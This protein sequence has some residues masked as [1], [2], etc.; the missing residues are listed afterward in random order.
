MLRRAVVALAAGLLA[1]PGAVRAQ[2][3]SCELVESQYAER[4]I[5][6]GFQVIHVVGPLRVVCAG[7]AEIRA[8]EGTLYE[9]TREIYLVGNVSYSDPERRLTSNNATYGSVNGR[10]HATGNVVF[11]DLT[12]GMTL[13]G[14]ELEYF[15]AMVGRPQAQAIATG[16]PH[17]VLQPRARAGEAARPADAQPV[18]VDADRMTM[19]GDDRLS[20]VGRVEIRRSDFTAFSTEAQ[21]D[22]ANDR[23]QLRGAARVH[24]EDFDLTG[25]VVEVFLPGE[26][27]ERVLAQQDA[28]LVGD[29]LRI[30]APEM[31]LFFADDVLQRLVAR[32]RVGGEASAIRRPV[33]SARAFRLEADSLDALLPGQQLERVVAIGDARGEAIDTAGVPPGRRTAPAPAGDLAAGDRDWITGDTVT[34]FFAPADTAAVAADAGEAERERPAEVQLER[35]LARGSARSLYRA[36]NESDPAQPPGLNYLVGETI[37]LSFRNGELEVAD[38]RGLQYGLYLDPAEPGQPVESLPPDERT[39]ARTGINRQR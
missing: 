34:G 2:A 7:G 17:L 31:H 21:L 37:E 10:L 26:S 32:N 16:R 28:V 35:L 29:D 24:A 36:Q 33:A 19:I 20:A 11:T 9:T 1:L 13:T 15:R 18:E 4:R 8:N 22:R 30:D 39:G 27:L 23:M 25:E 12:E 3:G 38:V 5:E 14:P 6:G